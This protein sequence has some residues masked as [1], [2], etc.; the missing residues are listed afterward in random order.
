MNG[1]R[2][3]NGSHAS[4][5]RS[6]LEHSYQGTQCILSYFPQRYLLAVSN[7]LDSPFTHPYLN[8][9]SWPQ[10]GPEKVND[11]KDQRL[12]GVAFCPA[13]LEHR[14][15]TPVE[16]YKK[17]VLRYCTYHYWL[18][19]GHSDPGG[20]TLKDYAAGSKFHS[21]TVSLP[22]EEEMRIMDESDRAKSS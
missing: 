14:V 8:F 6:F 1:N 16:H 18:M 11:T 21:F 9:R 15:K 3:L 4:R 17:Q 19:R 2:C 12:R 13:C 7:V 22:L 5:T 20:F 10:W